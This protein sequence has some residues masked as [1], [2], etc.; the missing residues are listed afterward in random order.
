MDIIINEGS[1]SNLENKLE[2]H[3]IM[4]YL[5][6]LYGRNKELS[7]LRYSTPWVET[8]VQ[9]SVNYFNC[10][11]SKFSTGFW[12]QFT[13]ELRKQYTR[14]N[15]KR[16]KGLICLCCTWSLLF[17]FFLRKGLSLESSKLYFFW[18]HWVFNLFFILLLF[19]T[20]PAVSFLLT[21]LHVSLI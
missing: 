4:L 3:S 2:V 21:H 11:F 20:D 18:N 1:L 17:C 9:R 12:L 14:P 15:C 6:I 7:I 8:T 16:I 13:F 10:C 19:T 5:L